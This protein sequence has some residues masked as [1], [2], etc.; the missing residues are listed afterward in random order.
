MVAKE[1]V[2]VHVAFRI[3]HYDIG[4]HSCVGQ[5]GDHSPAK[6]TQDEESEGGHKE[7]EILVVSAANTVIDPW[8]VV[9]KILSKNSVQSNII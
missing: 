6:A 3:L 4:E 8:T 1:Y 5:N 7:E 2:H 9:I